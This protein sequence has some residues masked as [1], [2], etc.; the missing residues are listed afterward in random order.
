MST[1]PA[2][3]FG[4]S[5]GKTGSRLTTAVLPSAAACHDTLQSLSKAIF[6]QLASETTEQPSGRGILRSAPI[7]SS[8]DDPL[9][10]PKETFP[11]PL[12]AVSLPYEL[13]LLD[14][15]FINPMSSHAKAS[16]YTTCKPGN[17]RCYGKQKQPPTDSG[18]V[19]KKHRSSS[20]LRPGVEGRGGGGGGHGSVPSAGEYARLASSFSGGFGSANGSGS[21]NGHGQGHANS[22]GN[23]GM[24]NG[25]TFFG[26]VDGDTGLQMYGIAAQM[27]H[28]GSSPALTGFT[29][30]MPSWEGQQGQGQ[31]QGNGGFTSG[32]L[33]TSS[34]SG[35]AKGGRTGMANGSAN[36][37]NNDAQHG[38]MSELINA[39][40]GQSELNES[41]SLSV[42]LNGGGGSNGQS[43]GSGIS[44]G[45]S[46]GTSNGNANGN[47]NGGGQ[48]EGGDGGF[49]LFNFLMDEEGGLGQGA[50]DAMEFATD[51]PFWS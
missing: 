3:Y 19:G 6:E 21:A 49:D 30:G 40:V 51:F 34:A 20:F 7:S 26:S 17:G 43:N 11:A 2:K 39:A 5:M 18:L 4:R 31:G 24:S 12:P 23:N 38:R 32:G 1:S 25:P 36:A 16:E 14:H 28:I 48:N 8:R 22:N 15:L 47:G 29:P 33:S 45:A 10:T 46:N 37:G 44:N 13:S 42:V 9:P 35:G 50:W 41:N 27:G